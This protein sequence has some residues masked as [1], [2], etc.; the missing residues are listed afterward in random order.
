MRGNDKLSSN[1]GIQIVPSSADN[2]T[3]WKMT[4]HHKGIKYNQIA[5]V[6]FSNKNIDWMIGRFYMGCSTMSMKKIKRGKKINEC[7]SDQNE[8]E[9]VHPDSNRTELLVYLI[10][11]QSLERTR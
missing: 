10:R 9:Y 5:A 4:L 8:Y 1:I 6:L 11:V 2:E 7:A 3:P